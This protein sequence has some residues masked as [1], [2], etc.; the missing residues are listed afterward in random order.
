MITINEK[1]TGKAWLK[2]VDE[3]LINGKES[4]DGDIKIL[5]VENIIINIEEPE[6]SDSIIE[7][8]GS[9]EA[10]KWM[11]DN[12][13]VLDKV[14]DLG[15][16]KSYCNRLFNYNDNNINQ[17]EFVINKLKNKKESKSATITTLNPNLKESYIPCISMLDFWIRDSKLQCIVYARSMDYG[18]KAYGNIIMIVKIMQMISERLNIRKGS[19]I[20]YVKSAHIYYS[21]IKEMEKIL[22]DEEK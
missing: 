21:N 20:I 9:P 6:E 1:T 5:E 14:E 16:A 3:I 17:I 13:F 7:K 4:F 18:K 19:L 8:H 2:V 11:Y 15:G 10:V 22:K 12:F